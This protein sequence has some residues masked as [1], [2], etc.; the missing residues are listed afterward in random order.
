[1]SLGLK[2]AVVFSESGEPLSVYPMHL[3]LGFEDEDFRLTQDDCG[4]LTHF[5]PFVDGHLN[6][7]SGGGETLRPRALRGLG[8][9]GLDGLDGFAHLARCLVSSAFDLA[10]LRIRLP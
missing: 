2:H 10:M 4:V 1:M 8:G 3:G 7:F 6:I 5:V 9:D